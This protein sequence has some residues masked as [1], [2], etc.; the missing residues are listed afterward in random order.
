LNLTNNIRLLGAR[1]DVP[2]VIQALDALIVNSHQ[3]PF[4]LTVL[5]GLASGIAVLATAV[6]GTPEMVQHN[7]NGWLVKSGDQDELASGLI[8][9]LGDEALRSRLGSCAR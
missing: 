3:E 9:L 1:D 8:R 5:E 4:A 6:G 7:V 2:K